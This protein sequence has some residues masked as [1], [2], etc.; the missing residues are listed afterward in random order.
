MFIFWIWYFYYIC[1]EQSNYKLLFCFSTGY[2]FSLL[3][4]L[5]QFE[6]L[7]TL[8]TSFH[9]EKKKIIPVWKDVPK[10]LLEQRAECGLTRSSG[11]LARGL[12]GIRIHPSILNSSQGIRSFWSGAALGDVQSSAL[13]FPT[14]SAFSPSCGMQQDCK[15]WG[16]AQFCEENNFCR[17]IECSELKVFKMWL[18]TLPSCAWGKEMCPHGCTSRTTANTWTFIPSLID[19]LPKFLLLEHPT[20]FPET[21]KNLLSFLET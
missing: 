19:L 17:I 2:F 21:G 7:S 4:S 16:F 1:S 13:I 15:K 3:L 18:C 11:S 6:K 14:G 10:A 8:S 5:F 20:V 12:D 9:S